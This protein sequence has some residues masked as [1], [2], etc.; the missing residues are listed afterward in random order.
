MSLDTKVF[1]GYSDIRAYGKR[2]L[3]MMSVEGLQA[4]E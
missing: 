2:W 4:T 3:G 1:G